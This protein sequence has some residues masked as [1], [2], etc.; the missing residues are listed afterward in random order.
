M[1]TPNLLPRVIDMLVFTEMRE[2]HATWHY[3][4]SVASGYRRE[5]ISPA[6][7]GERYC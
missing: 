4:L 6:G 7:N 2:H 1:A 3:V 5:T